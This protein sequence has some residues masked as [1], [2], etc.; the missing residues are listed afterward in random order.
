MD[1]VSVNLLKVDV[2][3]STGQLVMEQC[4]MDL[5]KHATNFLN[6][7]DNINKTYFEGLRATNEQLS[8]AR[9][10]MDQFNIPTV[11][12]A[13]R[14]S[15]IEEM[16]L[17]IDYM[18]CTYSRSINSILTMIAEKHR[19]SE[20]EKNSLVLISKL[21]EE[22]ME[23]MEQHK[24]LLSQHGE[25]AEALANNATEDEDKDTEISELKHEIEVLRS[26]LEKDSLTK[27]KQTEILN[28]QTYELETQN[29]KVKELTK[30][31]E[32]NKTKI[33]SLSNDLEMKNKKINVLVQYFQNDKKIGELIQDN[34][35]IDDMRKRMD[36]LSEKHE[37]LKLE[38]SIIKNNFSELQSKC[39]ENYSALD[40]E[41]RM[42]VK[43][44]EKLVEKNLMI[45]NLKKESSDQKRNPFDLSSNNQKN[46][47]D[48]KF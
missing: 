47:F 32:D 34:S 35:D 38:N 24:H 12:K 46:P 48:F 41:K 3:I 36:N 19:L 15:K 13:V 44:N 25:M 40:K 42:V 5:L 11:S 37:N 8:E 39:Q 7:H 9:A 20:H 10:L 26:N 28:S 30:I 1:S 45:E 18:I 2:I 14:V 31:V 16:K 17:N 22:K 21:K 23:L 33:A 6:G 43:L 27:R 4:C 29:E